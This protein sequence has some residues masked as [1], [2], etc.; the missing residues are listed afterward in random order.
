M[1][2]EF[3]LENWVNREGEEGKEREGKT[4]GS[5]VC[6]PEYCLKQVVITNGILLAG[7]Y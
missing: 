4:R 1:V 6:L 2:G 3:F 7:G 5:C